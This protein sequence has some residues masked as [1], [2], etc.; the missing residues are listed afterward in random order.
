MAQWYGGVKQ[1]TAQ[2]WDQVKQGF[3][4]A[5]GALDESF[6]VAARQFDTASVAKNK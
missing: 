5:Y 3:I 4:G 1:A 6:S 2:A